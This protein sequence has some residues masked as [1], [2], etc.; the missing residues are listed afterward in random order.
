MK[1]KKIVA[2]ELIATPTDKK[3]ILALLEAYEKANP[4]KYK[5]KKEKGEF[6]KLLA[7]K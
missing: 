6:D 7:D 2:G 4:T 1:E 5:I 3:E